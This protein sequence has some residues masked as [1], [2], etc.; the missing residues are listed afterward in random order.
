MMTELDGNEETSEAGKA[1]GDTQVDGTS[2][3]DGVGT[4]TTTEVGTSETGIDWVSSVVWVGL[5]A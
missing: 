5:T 1:T 4:A 2:A 3:T